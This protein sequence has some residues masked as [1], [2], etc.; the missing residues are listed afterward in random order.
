MPKNFIQDI[1]GKIQEALPEGVKNVHGE[2]ERFVKE[3]VDN[4]LSN[5]K[6]VRYEEFEIQQKILL[7]TREKLELLTKRVEALEAK[8]NAMGGEPLVDDSFV[9]EAIG[10]IETKPTED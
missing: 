3:G 10:V 8:L 5:F 2:A 7:K 4:A 9:V 6:F 1:A